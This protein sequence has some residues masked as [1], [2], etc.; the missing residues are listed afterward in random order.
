MK[1]IGMKS[2]SGYTVV[3]TL[4]AAA[5]LAGCP[6]VETHTEVLENAEGI[7]GK[8]LYFIPAV[9]D[10]L[11][12]LGDQFYSRYVDSA[13]PVIDVS[14]VEPIE[15]V[16]GSAVVALLQP[17]MYYGDFYDTIVVGVDGTIGFGQTGGG[18]RSLEQHFA[19]PQISVLPITAT[20]QGTEVRV[21]QDANGIVVDYAK[22]VIGDTSTTG[23]ND[24]S[25][26]VFLDQTRGTDGDIVLTYTKVDI[27][28]SGIVGFS[29]GQL[30][31]DP[32]FLNGFQESNLEQN[33]NTDGLR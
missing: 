6:R 12:R 1:G 24:N 11:K 21:F 8:E 27:T 16:N 3:A 17:V 31:S 9:S 26:Q 22:V 25:F 7:N 20:T 13:R 2:F 23:T 29:N 30:A 15:F 32:N 18:N 19:S 33:A 10:D 4:L 14:E 5:T 28:A